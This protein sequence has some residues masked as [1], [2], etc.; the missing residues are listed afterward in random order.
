MGDISTQT[1]AWSV[2]VLVFLFM[3]IICGILSTLK[4]KKRNGWIYGR[5]WGPEHDPDRLF[6]FPSCYAL[7]LM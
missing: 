7:Y 3:D 1:P 4:K 2:I 6:I 5:I